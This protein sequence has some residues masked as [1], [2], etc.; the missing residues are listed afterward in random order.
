MQVDGAERGGEEVSKKDLL[1]QTG[2]SYGQFYRWKRM[3]L[4]PESWF[5]RRSTFTGQETFLP[6]KKIMERLQQIQEL[7]DRYPL[8][9]IAEMLSPDIVRRTYQPEDLEHMGWITLRSRRLLPTR[10]PQAELGFLEVLCLTVMER[11]LATGRLRDEQVR[12]AGAAI[13]A[14][15]D[16]LGEIG[17]ERRLSVVA[18]G[19]ATIVLLHTGLCL[20]DGD[21]SVL[22]EVSLDHVIEEIK[23]ALMSLDEQ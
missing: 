17:A 3:G 12:Q 22:A 23:L 9:R 15:F 16:M 2:I 20:Y 11:L 5:R 7:K 8:E 19:G 18:G 6:R 4:I 10:S 14:K 13:L 21:C 1:R